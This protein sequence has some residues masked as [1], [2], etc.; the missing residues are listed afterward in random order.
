[1]LEP[2]RAG[3]NRVYTH[4]D[5]TRLKLTLR[6]K[7][8]GLSLQEIKQLVDMY[9]SGSD[10]R[11][12]L[13]AFLGVLGEH[14][15]REEQL[16]YQLDIEHRSQRHRKDIEGEVRVRAPRARVRLTVGGVL[17]EVREHL[18]PRQ[19]IHIVRERR[20]TND[21]D[22]EE[23]R[24]DNRD[25]NGGASFRPVFHGVYQGVSPPSESK[26]PCSCPARPSEGSCWWP[27][28]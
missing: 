21:P 9:E 20:K 2:S 3:R 7:R 23:K 10:E 8:L 26:D 14:R 18:R 16:S 17:A 28:P 15:E 27:P 6:G 24:D 1:M 5:R 25:R 22:R 12:Q 19:V 4:R 13:E 11:P